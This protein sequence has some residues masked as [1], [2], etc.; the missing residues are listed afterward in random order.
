MKSM[1]TTQLLRTFFTSA[2]AVVMCL[3]TAVPALAVGGGG[4]TTVTVTS[5]EAAITK[6]LKMPEGTTTPTADFIFQFTKKS[7][8]G[9]TT[10]AELDRMPDIGTVPVGGSAGEIAIPFTSA[11]TGTTINDTKTIFKQ[12]GNI[13]DG[14]TFPSAGEYTYT[15]TEK[16]DTYSAADNENMTYSGAEYLM[17]FYVKN[18][19]TGTGTFVYAISAV[20][21]TPDPGNP[22]EPGD[23]VDPTP[24]DG[25]GTF[26]ELVFTN[27]YTK[28]GGGTDPTNPAEQALA[29]SKT[30]TG[31]F[32][33]KNKSFEYSVLA[34]QPTVVTGTA[35]YKAYVLEGGAVV[36]SSENTAAT[37]ETDD[38]GNKYF[39]ITAD[40]TS[41]VKLKHGQT[42]VFTD[43]YVGARYEALEQG[44][45]GYTP[46]VLVTE[47]GATP[48]ANSAAEG[49]PLSTNDL[50]NVK[51]LIG[52]NKNAADFTNEYTATITP[53]GVIIDNLPFVMILLL[54]AG[55]FAAFILVKARKR[56]GHTSS[57]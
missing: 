52:E 34:T 32:G 14:V 18:N 57:H 13:L 37:L 1:K 43:I 2:L 20:I 7:L 23:K 28:N 9:D 44:N 54:A 4:G 16:P 26:S 10:S 47:N 36:T 41:T 11:D 55:A 45:N 8:G 40:V 6:T 39:E 35:K 31:D 21:V 38:F 50:N 30:V 5:P 3:G 15:L 46:S 19:S 25:S 22:G 27:I 49:A 56:R 12:S 53:T 42:L 33:D 29:I 17:T 51:R 24:G 48:V